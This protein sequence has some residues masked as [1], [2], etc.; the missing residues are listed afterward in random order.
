MIF[1]LI[2]SCSCISKDERLDPF[3]SRPTNWHQNDAPAT[4]RQHPDPEKAI[5]LDAEVKKFSLPSRMV[6]FTR[7]LAAATSIAALLVS[8]AADLTILTPGGPD[9][10][11]GA[12]RV[13]RS[14][15]LL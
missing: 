2:F 12:Y 13:I 9:L 10:W 6:S 4:P 7:V 14:T 1:D 5:R 8:T 11:W 3:I 15:S